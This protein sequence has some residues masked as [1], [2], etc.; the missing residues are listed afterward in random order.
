[1]KQEALN[2]LEE[3]KRE[4]QSLRREVKGIPGATVN[5]ASIRNHADAIATMW[6]E[7]LR[8]QL[9]HKFQLPP[10]VIEEMAEHM[11]RLHVLSR[12]SNRTSS[13]L[14]VIGKALDDFDDKFILPIKQSATTVESIFDL[15]KLVPGLAT[16]EES[17]YLTEA[18][19]CAELGHRRAAIVMGWCAAIDRLQKAVLQIGLSKFNAASAKIKNQTTGRYK[20]WN[21]QFS[22][23]SLR[24][25][26]EVFDNDLITV[27][28][29]MELFDG[30]QV[31]RLRTCFQYRNHSAHPGQAPIGDANVVA[32]FTDINAMI[33]QNPKLKAIA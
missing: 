14:N 25:L 21:K 30:N 4:L 3:F 11:K 9:E 29:G 33:F 7:D 23:A 10:G 19:R 31:D 17:D 20:N 15:Q 2:K 18:V 1:M 27:L 8:S 24:D 22:L 6:V 13:Y 32:F 26:Q 12:P 5:K 16:A 28:E